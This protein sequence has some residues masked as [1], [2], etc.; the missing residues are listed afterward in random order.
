[1]WIAK[2]LAKAKK[3]LELKEEILQA[4]EEVSKET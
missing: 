1:V 4:A 2:R 3:A